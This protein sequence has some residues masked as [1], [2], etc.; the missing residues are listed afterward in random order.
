MHIYGNKQR[1][2]DWWG[3]KRERSRSAGP[4]QGVVVGADVRRHS[5]A[6]GHM[7]LY[8][9]LCQHKEAGLQSWC[10]KGD[11][12]RLP[13]HGPGKQPMDLEPEGLKAWSAPADMAGPELYLSPGSN[14]HP[15]GL[16]MSFSRPAGRIQPRQ[17][18]WH[19]NS[20]YSRVISGNKPVICHWE[21]CDI[22]TPFVLCSPWFFGSTKNHSVKGS[23]ENHVFLTFL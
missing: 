3:R 15:S 9:S 14:F 19:K 16:G 7:A 10:G 17:S 6:S 11:L 23:L 22:T 1:K 8:H 4:W 12:V 21:C 2:A 5:R 18:S 13:F 20:L